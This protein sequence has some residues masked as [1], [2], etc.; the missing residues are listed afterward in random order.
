MVPA[1]ACADAPAPIEAP[2][3]ALTRAE[4]WDEAEALKLE[5][6]TLGFYVSSH[7]L[8]QHR[9]T[10]GRFGTTD[11][12]RVEGAADNAR[13]CIGGLVQSVR[14]IV[15]R[16]GRNPGQKM[17]IVTLEDLLGTIECVLFSEAYSE[18]AHM[19]RADEVVLLIGTVDRKRGGTQLIVDRVAPVEEAMSLAASLVVELDADRLNGSGTNTLQ[20]LRGIL[21]THAGGTGAQTPVEIKVKTG[22][23][24]VVLRAAEATRVRPTP[25]LLKR[26]SSGGEAAVYVEGVR[27]D[28][29][30]RKR[31]AYRAG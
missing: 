8:E 20:F 11:T 15:T 29:P 30:Q 1:T 27:L 16:N 6:E 2:V 3:A 21:A 4:A 31:Q 14:P 10:I 22:D 13:V 18:F 19:V 24:K 9:E 5:K 12:S 17:A 23:A 26:L 25:E 7:P 28:A